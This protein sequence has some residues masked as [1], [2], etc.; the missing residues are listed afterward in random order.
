MEGV[1]ADGAAWLAASGLSGARLWAFLVTVATVGGLAVY[2]GFGSILYGLYYV[3]RRDDPA[4]WK[5]QPKRFTPPKLHR[6]AISVAAG[7]LAMGGI[8]TGTLAYWVSQ[9]GPTAL[10]LDVA[11]YGWAYTIFSTALAFVLLDGIA[12]YVHRC[13]HIKWVFRHVHRW[14]HRVIAPTPFTTTTMHPAEFLALQAT[15]FLPIFV[16]PIWV[17][18]FI[19]LLVYVLIFNMMDHSGIDMR[20][21]APW[22]SSSRYHDD[23]HVHFHCNFGQN[24]TF[25]DR[26]HGTL[27]R[28][29]RRYGVEVFGGRGRAGRA[30]DAAA[31]DADD[32]YVDYYKR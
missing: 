4:S 31:D 29:D 30:G 5:L 32:P 14:H 10:Y 17:W 9:G 20:H 6:W 18:S 23:H 22:Q 1:I 15:A 8:L 12:Y 21:W 11:D 16:L 26:L 3:R 24:L 13:L 27:R 25:F 2:F 7:N 28:R 19:G